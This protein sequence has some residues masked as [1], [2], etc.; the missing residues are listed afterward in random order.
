MP[1]RDKRPQAINRL[2]VKRIPRGLTLQKLGKSVLSSDISKMRLRPKLG[3]IN[4]SEVS[5]HLL[6]NHSFKMLPKSKKAPFLPP[7]RIVLSR[8]QVPPRLY[9]RLAHPWVAQPSQRQIVVN[10]A[11]KW[12]SRLRFVN[13][14]SWMAFANFLTRARLLTEPMSWSRDRT[15]LE[16]T[17]PSNASAFTKSCIALTVQDASSSTMN[18]SRLRV[19]P[20]KVQLKPWH[21]KT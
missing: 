7:K 21:R 1:H 20:R 5:R 12:S 10:K 18:H 13:S 6:L 2:N 9:R 11:S 17:R 14:G 4:V 15:S 19:L 3:K 8:I 16:T